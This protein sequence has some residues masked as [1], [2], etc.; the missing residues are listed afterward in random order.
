MS[1]GC[2]SEHRC[3]RPQKL[4]VPRWVH[5]SAVVGGPS[6]AAVLVDEDLDRD[7]PIFGPLI[8]EHEAIFGRPCGLGAF[9]RVSHPQS[10]TGLDFRVAPTAGS[11]GRCPWQCY[12]VALHRIIAFEPFVFDLTNPVALGDTVAW[13]CEPDR[14]ERDWP[15]PDNVAW[16]WALLSADPEDDRFMDDADPEDVILEGRLVS[17]SE[18][19]AIQRQ[20]SRGVWVPESYGVIEQT[21]TRPLPDPSRDSGHEFAAYLFGLESDR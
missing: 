15:W 12:E 16:E 9:I 10:L 21:S 19:R 11:G 6:L 3:G 8:D 7:Q 14:P 4:L 5:A 20:D 1:V 18:V 13:G 17:I 2:L